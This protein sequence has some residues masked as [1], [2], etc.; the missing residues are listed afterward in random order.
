MKRYETTIAAACLALGVVAGCD[1]DKLPSRD[2]IPVLRER[3]YQL[4]QAVLRRSPLAIDSMASIEL[5]DAGLSSDSLLSFVYGPEDDFAFA[6]FDN[7]SIFYNRKFAVVTCEIADSTGEVNRPV[8]LVFS[9]HDK[10]WLLKGFETVADNK[11][12]R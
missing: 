1:S 8:K 10:A 9:K 3:V 11:A 4:E 5:L 2:E 12:D 7:Y 6:R